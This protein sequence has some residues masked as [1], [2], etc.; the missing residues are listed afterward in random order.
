MVEPVASLV[1]QLLCFETPHPRETLR[2]WLAEGEFERFQVV[3][4]IG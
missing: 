4:L 1:A 3:S 2:E